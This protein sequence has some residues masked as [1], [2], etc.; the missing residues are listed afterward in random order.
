[1]VTYHL[2]IS[3]KVQGVW[4]RDWTV[5]QALDIGLKGWV[6]NLK[7]GNV[8]AVIQGEIEIVE[9]ML[10]KCHTGSKLSNVKD[11]ESQR[12]ESDDIFTD[13]EKRK[14]V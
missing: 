13:F 8:E 5:E 11:V 12:I 1:M 7:N 6:R 9:L 2:I 10:E 14:T 3:G 4:Y